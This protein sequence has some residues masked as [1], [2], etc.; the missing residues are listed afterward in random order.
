MENRI[1]KFSVAG[2]SLGGKLALVTMESFPDRIEHLVLLAPDGVRT[3]VWYNL[4]TYP[5]FLR[6]YFKSLIHHPK[7]LSRIV[8]VARTLKLADKGVLRFV[9]NQMNTEEKRTRV[10][11]SWIVFR[12]LIFDLQSIATLITTYKIQFTLFVGKHD[13]V[14]PPTSMNRLLKRLKKP[15]LYVLDAGHNDLIKHA[16]EALVK[17]LI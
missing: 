4:A 13:K 5:I 9:E 15:Q 12:H 2:F 1:E 14:I 17:K 3:S 16:S 10:Y 11:Y 8:R 6:K 7:R